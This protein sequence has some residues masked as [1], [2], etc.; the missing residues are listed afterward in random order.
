[1]VYGVHGNSTILLTVQGGQETMSS[2]PHY[3]PPP[4]RL[5][6]IKMLELTP[7]P[8]SSPPPP[9]HHLPTSPQSQP[10][11]IR[12]ETPPT[13]TESKEVH[14]EDFDSRETLSGQP[15]LEKLVVDSLSSSSE[16]GSY[17]ERGEEGEGEKGG[18]PVVG[19]ERGNKSGGEE[20]GHTPNR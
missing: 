1:M 6:P 16:G 10:I 13:D 12:H 14:N 3:S 11:V 2:L 5:T 9:P 20:T 17:E 19:E 18:H 15:P 8:P 7:S 4:H